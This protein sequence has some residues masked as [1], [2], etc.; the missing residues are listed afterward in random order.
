MDKRVAAVAKE[1]G[2]GGMRLEGRDAGCGLRVQDRT[3]RNMFASGAD[4]LGFGV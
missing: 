4:G 3:A 2:E 1:R